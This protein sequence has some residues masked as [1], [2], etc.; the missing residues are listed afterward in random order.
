M[1][2]WAKRRGIDF[3]LTV[4]DLRRWLV[5]DGK[6]GKFLPDIHLERVDKDKGFVPENLGVKN[7]KAL[8]RISKALEKKR[9]AES[10]ANRRR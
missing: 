5:E 2:D 10:S 6:Y 3:F 7:Y 4:D 8:E 1:R 9:T